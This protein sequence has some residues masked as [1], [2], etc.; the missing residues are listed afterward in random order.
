[1]QEPDIDSRMEVD[2]NSDEDYDT[3][4]AV[5]KQNRK[6]KKSGGFQSMGMSTK[7]GGIH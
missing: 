4:N 7:H 6:N 3:R 1:M 5:M 2:E